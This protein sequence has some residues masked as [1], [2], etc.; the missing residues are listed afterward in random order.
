[1]SQELLLPKSYEFF[2]SLPQ[3]PDQ[4][5]LSQNILVYFPK[6]TSGL[7]PSL[8]RTLLR[9]VHS[10]TPAFQYPYYPLT[11]E[12]LLSNLRYLYV[13]VFWVSHHRMILLS[14]IDNPDFRWNLYEEC[15]HILLRF[16]P[17]LIHYTQV[18]WELWDDKSK[19]P[20]PYFLQLQASPGS[21]L[22]ED[23]IRFFSSVD[24]P[25]GVP[26]HLEGYPQIHQTILQTDLFSA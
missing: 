8:F 6:E 10:H 23:S 1:M 20:Y 7:L 18:L 16:H 17:M 25:E 19:L 2:R 5:A 22:Y 9:R 26:S 15:A 11:K 12:I 13:V 3:K 4:T 14:Q 24:L 21:L